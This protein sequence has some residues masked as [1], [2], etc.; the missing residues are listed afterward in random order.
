[1]GIKQV[2]S[3]KQMLGKITSLDSNNYPEMLGKTCIINAPS[4]F[5]MIFGMVKPF[6]DARTRA[7]VEVGITYSARVGM[8]TTCVTACSVSPLCHKHQDADFWL[9][10][11]RN[12]VPGSFGSVHLPSCKSLE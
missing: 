6:L 3:V 7:K 10:R 1:M 4:G 9:S 8:L 2:S 11:C 5:G 12:C